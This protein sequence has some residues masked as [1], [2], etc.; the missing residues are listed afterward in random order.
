[1]KNNIR[2][3][4]VISTKTQRVDTELEKL[5]NKKLIMLMRLV[6]SELKSNPDKTL[7][8]VIASILNI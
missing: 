1:M 7:T 2:K 3:T 8:D 5:D 4:F 6:A